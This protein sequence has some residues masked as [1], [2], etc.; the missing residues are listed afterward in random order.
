MYVLNIINVE[1]LDDDNSFVLKESTVKY[2]CDGSFNRLQIQDD[3]F[4]NLN[5]KSINKETMKN[6]TKDKGKAYKISETN[7]SIFIDKKT[8]KEYSFSKYSQSINIIDKRVKGT[9]S[10][11]LKEV[12]NNSSNRKY[13]NY[14]K[15]KHLKDAKYGFYKYKITFSIINDSNEDIYEGIVLIRN[16][17]NTKKYL[18]DILDIKKIN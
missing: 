12:I 5:Y 9:L 3:S 18:Y 13:V 8:S 1:I 10:K 16:D 2:N 4:N 17:A 14:K 7:N 11:Y 6:I 15:E